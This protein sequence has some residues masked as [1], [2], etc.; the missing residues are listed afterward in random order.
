M[1]QIWSL[2]P[3]QAPEVAA[4][5]TALGLPLPVARL[6]WLRGYR[7]PKVA[8]DFLS[9]RDRLDWLQSPL[10]TDGMAR[11]VARIRR[12][13]AEQEPFV[14]YGDYD[15]DGVT[16]T[17]LLYRYLKRGL[18]ANCEAYLP[19]RFKDGYGV[20][21]AAV[22]RIAASG[23]RLILTCDNGISAIAAAETARK[24]GVEIVVTD[25]HQ[26][27]EV[28]PD[29]T[30]I[31]HPALEF[32]HL[33]DLAGVGVALLFVIAL[34][35]GFNDRI[36]HFLD[37]VSIGTVG[38]VVSL[39]GPNRALV[40]A[41]L[42]RFR[43]GKS[44]F[45][46]I[47]ALAKTAGTQLTSVRAED[48]A[49]Q[50]V[51]R[52]NAAGRL[53]TPRVGFELLTTNDHEQAAVHAE[54]LDRINRERRTMSA[55]LQSDIFQRLDADWDLESEPFIV[56]ADEGF[57]HG[58]TG[59]IAGRIKDRY[60]CPVLLFSGHP[61]G[62]WKASGRSPDGLHL[63]DALHHARA[64][65]VGFGGHAGAAG[66]AAEES[67]IP[68]VRRALNAYVREVGWN[69]P[70]DVI[71]LD[72]EL[73]FAEADAALLEALDR[74]EPFGQRNPSPVFGLLRARVVGRRVV[75]N[76][77][78]LKVDDGVSLAEVIAWGK[79]DM[80]DSLG[81]WIRFTYRP[82]WNT[83]QGQTRIQF[84]ADRLAP[85][86]AVEPSIAAAL[87]SATAPV[88]NDRRGQP[89]EPPRDAHVYAIDPPTAGLWVDPLAPSVP[90]GA[91]LWF[92]DPP[93]DE[94]TWQQLLAQ[95]AQVTLAWPTQ[96]CEGAAGEE[97][98]TPQALSSL[99]GQLAR[100]REGTLRQ[101]LQKAQVSLGS[102]CLDALRIFEEAGLL[103]RQ[104]THWQLLAAPPEDI[105]LVDLQS[106]QE[107][108]NGLRFRRALRGQPMPRLQ[109]SL[110]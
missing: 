3:A 53:E 103:L 102:A 2:K 40:W 25:H 42:A 38:D 9:T 22:E 76:H 74:L 101:A 11:A 79:A 108:L 12:A 39:S 41:G 15:C 55:D 61:G 36:A 30:A 83:F 58:I 49:F 32:P 16:S 86:S 73:P 91:H 37:F 56:L 59:I 27:P 97:L 21:P 20:T 90:A 51:P 78:F 87:A 84:I 23:V 10:E 106:Y 14:I 62:L 1:S 47:A 54:V 68:L 92:C 17:S 75:K 100:H 63:Y 110:G 5:A 80:A 95:A 60:R 98:P 64:H 82:S 44:R 13:V 52:L 94:Q 69:R 88:W 109:A 50:L 43:E 85:A 6:L 70:A 89:A 81:D 33:K 18:K 48:L 107:A 7:T 77:L 8:A 35:G 105:A 4:I 66:C 99:W 93:H 72:A 24:L 46:G 45:P 67:A 19:D 29:V 31:V 26:P 104:G 28:L 71:A 65:L 34:E 57:H 96:T